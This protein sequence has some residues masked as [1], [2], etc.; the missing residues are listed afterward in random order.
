MSNPRDCLLWSNN[1]LN[2]LP[3]CTLTSLKKVFEQF[4]CDLTKMQAW[5]VMCPAYLPAV[6]TFLC[7]SW[8]CQLPI[9]PFTSHSWTIWNY[10]ALL[11]NSPKFSNSQLLQETTLAPPSKALKMW[12]SLLTPPWGNGLERVHPPHFFAVFAGETSTPLF[13]YK[14]PFS[15]AACN[16]LSIAIACLPCSYQ[17]NTSFH[18]V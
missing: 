18:S 17:F 12:H 6:N 8:L 7:K 10:T 3:L 15:L 4:W 16:K 14:K 13:S 1:L 11:A 5:P 2:V 9:S